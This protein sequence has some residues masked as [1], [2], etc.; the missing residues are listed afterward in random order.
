LPALPSDTLEEWLSCIKEENLD[1]NKK[2]GNR[3]FI[4]IKK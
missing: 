4:R 1:R 3:L 2:R